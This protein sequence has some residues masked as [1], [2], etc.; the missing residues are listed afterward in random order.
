MRKRDTKGMM[1]CYRDTMTAQDIGIFI[2][3]FHH[4]SNLATTR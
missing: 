2:Q 3:E 1:R 4:Q